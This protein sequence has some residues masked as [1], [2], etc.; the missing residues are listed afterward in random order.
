MKLKF[1]MQME[2]P[3]VTHQEK[4]VAVV[5]GK[6]RVYEDE[7][8]RDARAKLTAHLARHRPVQPLTGPLALSVSW[9]FPDKGESHPH[10]AYRTSK[11]DTDNLN[12]LLKDC[13]TACGFWNDDA[14]VVVETI[15][16]IW[17]RPEQTV[18][19]IFM[20]VRQLGEIYDMGEFGE[21]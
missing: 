18:P 10:G 20:E 3:T 17:V 8:L 16:K 2:P 9:L 21:R 5:R 15:V 14:Q 6:P 1:F 11:P 13:M 7:R 12:K 4:R 19:G